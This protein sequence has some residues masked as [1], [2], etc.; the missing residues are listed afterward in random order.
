[1]LPLFSSLNTPDEW[2]APALETC[3]TRM[4]IWMEGYRGSTELGKLEDG[5]GTVSTQ[6][7]IAP[8]NVKAQLK[9]LILDVL[10]DDDLIQR[11]KNHF[12][13]E[14]AAQYLNPEWQ[15]YYFAAVDA[16]PLEGDLVIDRRVSLKASCWR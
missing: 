3:L 10:A 1:M 14:Q 15:P 12:G 11:L 7:R 9:Q 4:D 16:L 6:Y 2:L 13:E 5:T 8:S